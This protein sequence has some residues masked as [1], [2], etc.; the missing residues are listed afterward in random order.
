[1]LVR[2]CDNEI[3]TV[4]ERYLYS[5]I[6]GHATAEEMLVHF[7]NGIAAVDLS[8][9]VPVSIDGPSQTGSFMKIFNN[10]GEKN[11]LTS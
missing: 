9:L 11:Y 6:F 5:E 3:N 7:K 1:M 4:M 8:C 10:A 2:F